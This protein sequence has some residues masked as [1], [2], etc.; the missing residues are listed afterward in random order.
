MKKKILITGASG[1]IGSC[2]CTFLSK[3]FEVYAVDKKKKPEWLRISK[4]KFF[5]INLTNKKKVNWLLNKVKPSI[6]IHLAALSTVN[7]TIPKSKYLKNNKLV[8]EILIK[9]MIKNNIKKIIFSSTA[10]V[11]KKKLSNIKETDKALPIN[12]YG[13][14]KLLT[15]KLIINENNIKSVILRFFNVTSSLN[16]GLIGEYHKPETHLIPRVVSLIS[17]NRKIK[18]YGKNYA[19]PDKTCIRDYIHIHDICNAIKK[20]IKYLSSSHSKNQIINLGNEKG[21]S[22]LSIIKQAEKIMGKKAIISIEKRRKGDP[23]KLVC[24]IEKAKKII[25]WVPIKSSIKKIINDEIL[26]NK[27]L[28]AKNIFRV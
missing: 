28:E 21:I 24:S 23:A 5:K 17:K 26:W 25:K 14:S 7:E 3:I 12:N 16:K 1:Y 27:K 15:E 11:Y 8:T 4:S 13:K 19:T 6:I 18:I 9:M 22:V 2:L 20:S 10:A